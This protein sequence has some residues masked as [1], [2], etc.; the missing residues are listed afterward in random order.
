MH[1]SSLILPIA[2]VAA[3]ATLLPSAAGAAGITTTDA[4][5]VKRGLERLVAARDGPPG[6]IAT[7]HRGGRTIVLRAGRAQVGRNGAPRASDH[8]RI[9]SVAKAYNAAIALRLVQDGRLGLDD[10]IAQRA[11]QLPAAWGA[12]TVRQMLNHTSGLPDYTRSDGFARHAQTAPAAYVAPDGIIDW[13]RADPLA[14][15]PDSRYEYSNTDN[16]VVGLIAEAVTG[17]PYGTL[18]SEI[19]FGPAKLT[20]TSFPRVTALPRPFLH[21][22]VVGDGRAQDVSTFLNPS[23]AW[24]SG[25]IVATPSD[26]GRFIRA[27]LDRSFFGAD[28]QREQLRFRPGSSSPAGPGANAAG[29]GIFRYST[30]CG[31]VYGHTGNF[32]GYVQFAAATRDGSRSVTTSLNIPAP[33]GALLRQ[34]RALQAT[35][36]CALL[37]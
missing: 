15:T 23:G 12:V 2:T 19:V 25:G 18:L 34:L 1:R 7:L 10:T 5:A 3:A 29:L 37:R 9:A 11:P 24:A 30:R 21:G 22:Y 31:V 16:I 14:F 6:A 35:A 17:R 27:D 4:A 28:Q 33:A 32:P 36:V 13:V 8:M 26:L 20:A